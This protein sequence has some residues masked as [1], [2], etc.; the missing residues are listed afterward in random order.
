MG[1]RPMRQTSVFFLILT[2]ASCS[3]TGSEI[4]V[5]V[6]S[7]Q[8]HLVSGGDAL[9]EVI[10]SASSGDE[11]QLTV[12]GESQTVEFAV[13]DAEDGNASYRGLVTGLRVGDNTIEVD[14]S[15][16]RAAI[17]VVNYP[18]T[19][20]IISGPHQE[21]YFCLGELAPG[22]RGE[23]PRF[24]IGNEDY[25]D[26]TPL[27]NSCSLATRV[28]YVYR[29]TMPDAAF[30]PFI[31]IGQR[32]LDLATITT[33]EGVEAPYIVRIE[34][35]T[36]NRAIYQIAIL[37]D[38]L[39]EA[40]SPLSPPV[41]WNGRL[42]YTY[43][44]GCEAGFFQGASTGGVLRNNLLSKGYAVASS[45]LNVN[46]QGG[47]NDVLSA[48]TTMMVKEHFIE[49]FGEPRYTIGN[50]GSGGAMQQLLIAGAYPGLLDGI[51]PSLTFSDAITY[52][53]DTQEC[54][55]P[56]R[57]F[58][59]D[60][61]RGI[62]EDVKAAIG[63]W[64]MWSVCDR[65]LGN[66]PA[67][68]S[69][70]DCSAQIPL[71]K[72]YDAALN[73]G[74]VRCSIYDGMRNI[75]GEAIFAGIN[76]DR[77]FARSPH[78]NVGVQYGLATLNEGIIDKAFFLE[79]NEEI[80][81]WDIDFQ[82]QRERTVGDDDAIRIAYETGR[83]TSG[84]AGLS[85]VPIID[86]RSYLDHQGNFHASI[87][88]FTTRARLE[89]D[90]GHAGN[91]VIRRHLGG[92]SLGD[93]SLALM[94]RWLANIRAD[95]SDLR[96][97]E[98]IVRAKPPELQD[99]CWTEAGERIVEKAVFDRDRLFDNTRGACNELY[100]PHAGLRLVAGGPLSND[101]FKCQLKPID[102]G[103][104]D[105]EFTDAE[106]RRLELIFEEGVCDWSRPGV[107]QAVNQTWLSYGPSPA[108]RYEPGDQP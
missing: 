65:S 29:S 86:D 55:L 105:V 26:D 106:K 64:S 45:S 101:V 57:N 79:L 62:S 8:A 94:D 75:F 48:E 51:M 27:D 103:D 99:D 93:E 108:N 32:P 68:I 9:I 42:V 14:V 3:P 49:T 88:S 81:G 104:Y 53:V 76:G 90:N 18:I 13:T 83:V 46:A 95:H 21:P 61:A 1:S 73:P 100:P 72:Q 6:V 60:E 36:I 19:G 50:G 77:P 20:P 70:Y 80:G 10:A 41:A 23:R 78:D 15:Y 11:L 33:I 92:V 4:G 39:A 58:L 85:Q 66:R 17:T 43:G 97:L 63:A 44:G 98:K 37:H 69:P 71:A 84:G 2:L 102:Y 54:S 31:D 56:L 47:C 30:L 5:R 89:R 40:A 34:T 59:N 91:Y 87:Y 28:D 24:A 22:R 67:R 16:G 25:L 7:T 52:F 74:G 107:H 38:P 82:P 96:P 12:N 35:G